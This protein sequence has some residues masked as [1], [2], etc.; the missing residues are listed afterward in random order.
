VSSFDR[1]EAAEWA[2]AADGSAAKMITGAGQALADSARRGFPIPPGET[3][4]QILGLGL[5]VKTSLVQAN[6][7]I[8]DEG[9]ARIFQVDEFEIKLIVRLA[10]LGMEL[11]RER[12]FNA[13]ALEE[14]EAQAVT[15]RAKADVERRNLETE[16]RM[17]GV[18]RAKAEVEQGI[19]VFK[20]QLVTAQ[21]ENLAGEELL[22]E[23]QLETAEAKLKI[24]DSIY[25]VIAAEELVL[26]AERRRAAS[27]EEVLAAQKIV[28]AIKK[29]MV[30]FYLAKAAA[31]EELAVAVTQD[32]AVRE[33]IERLGYDRLELKTAEED[34]NHVIR[35]AEEDHELA[36]Q[37][38]IQAEKARRVAQVQLRRLLQEY[39][40]QV[41]EEILAQK[42]DL[43][44]D[45]VDFKLFL[46]LAR[47]GMS[48]DED[49]ALLMNKRDILNQELNNLLQNMEAAARAQAGAIS[50]SGNTSTTNRHTDHF[51][52][53]IIKGSGFG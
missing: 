31:R 2:Q 8:Y 52:R 4:D 39:H 16:A 53:R 13:L 30:P 19:T 21:E 42:E 10:K 40:N 3:L 17:A 36:Q 14:A 38:R 29:E 22:I 33:E 24:I 47:L 37:S 28:A 41:Q 23:A 26:A 49:V 44:K 25:Q 15:E 5:E 9:R 6:G 48:I 46:Q 27:L 18:I 11:Y 45:G 12:L 43:A 20:Q 35:Q 1:K 32:A 7:K 50:A 51:T 34:L